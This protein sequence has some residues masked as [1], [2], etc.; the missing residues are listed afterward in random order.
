ME[1]FEILFYARLS[2]VVFI[3]ILFLQSGLDKILDFNGNKAYVKSVFEKTF[4][5]SLSGLLFL[6]ITVLEIATGIVALIGG[7]QMCFNQKED[8]ALMALFLSSASLLS[9]FAGQRIAK[10]YGGASG[11]V[12]YFI[13]IVLG[14]YLFAL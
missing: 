10:D 2:I 1:N 7:L 14:L 11:I 8:L 13:V 6:S 9:L 3:A 12:P 4:L 5:A